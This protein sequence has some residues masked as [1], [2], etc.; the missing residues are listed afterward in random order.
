MYII[1]ITELRQDA[2]KV[3]KLAASSKEPV[4]IVQRSNPVAYL[5]DAETFERMKRQSEEPFTTTKKALAELA[6]LRSQMAV[7]GRQ[8][9]S[10][11]FLR[12]LR[13]GYLR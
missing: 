6:R 9:D 7:R 13:E 10:V 5:I 8:P 1:S 3:I 11:T 12:E 2:S 4:L